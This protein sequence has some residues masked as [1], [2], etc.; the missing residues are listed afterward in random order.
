MAA[1]TAAVTE[2]AADGTDKPN[3][4][5]RADNSARQ[6]VDKGTSALSAPIWQAQSLAKP[7]LPSICTFL[8]SLGNLLFQ[9]TD[10]LKLSPFLVY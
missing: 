10:G 4:T 8:G 6:T 1:V 2:A 9:Q 5:R 3:K 7:A